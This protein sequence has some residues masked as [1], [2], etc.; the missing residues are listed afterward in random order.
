MTVAIDKIRHRLPVSLAAATTLIKTGTVDPYILLLA[1][2]LC[3]SLDEPISQE[4]LIELKMEADNGW[5]R[6]AQEQG[7]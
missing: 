5:F 2:H 6:I 4:T 7:F 3:C 1:G